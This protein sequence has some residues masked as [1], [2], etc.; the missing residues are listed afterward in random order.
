[1]EWWSPSLP[2]QSAEAFLGTQG[3]PW[4]TQ[5]DMF[6]ALCGALAALTL[7]A[8]MHDRS[9]TELGSNER[10]SIFTPKS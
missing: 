1:V 2:G 5:W 3:D 10:S 4:D 7:L 6:L 9:L 8:R